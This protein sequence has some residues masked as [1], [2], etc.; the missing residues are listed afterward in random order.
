MSS[1]RAYV[2]ELEG[3]G[4][5]HY[6]YSDMHLTKKEVRFLNKFQKVFNRNENHYAQGQDDNGSVRIYF[7]KLRHEKGALK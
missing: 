4:G 7:Y 2:I 3:G 6:N 1:K 5:S